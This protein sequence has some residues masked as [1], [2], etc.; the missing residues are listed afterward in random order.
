MQRTIQKS[1]ISFRKLDPILLF[2][3]AIIFSAGLFFLFSASYNLSG[4]LSKDLIFRQI[5]SMMIVI[6]VAFTIL[7]VDYRKIVDFSPFLYVLSIIFLVLVLFW[8]NARLGAQR[9]LTLAGFSFQPSEFAKIVLI[10][11]LANH[12]GHNRESINEP[13]SIIAPILMVALPF[14]LIAAEPDLGTALVL[15]PIFAAMMFVAGINVKSLLFFL[16]FGI[17]SSPLFWHFLKDYQKKRLMVFLNPNIDP[18]GAGY[19]IIQSKIAIGSGCLFG[20]GWLSGT[21]NQLNFLPERH[22]DFIFSVVGEEWGFLGSVVIVLL[23]FLIIKRGIKI[24]SETPDICGKA[25][26]TGVI[27]LFSFQ[28]FVNIGMA[29]GLLPVVGLTLPFISYGGSSLIS[30]MIALGLLL[31]VGMRRP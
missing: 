29:L 10:L 15:L 1:N 16:A 30:S 20:K 11:I 13:R 19:T 2:C 12:V 7:I 21:Q 26:A 24:M 18:L 17:I 25:L 8:G 5:F 9:W 14:L 27:A 3:V 31:N 22:T 4:G 28:I 6:P 23:Y